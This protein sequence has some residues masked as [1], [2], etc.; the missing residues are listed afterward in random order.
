MEISK[1]IYRRNGKKVYIKQPEFEE[2]EFVA[3]L[4]SDED[5]MR[6]IGGVYD[7][8][9][10]KREIFYKN[11]VSPTDGKNFYCLVYENLEGRVVGEVSFH[12]YDS[13]TKC[14][15]FN[16]KINYK[17]RNK[18]YGEESLKLLL[19]YYFHD[20]GGKVV[21]DNIKTL[22]GIKLLKKVGFEILAKYKD[23]IRVRLSKEDYANT[24]LGINK[25][26][27]ILMYDGM[28][29]LDYSI[30]HDVLKIANDISKENIFEIKG[31]SFQNKIKTYSGFNI[32]T[33]KLVLNGDILIIP[34]GQN[35]DKELKDKE[36]IQFLNNNFKN[37]DFICSE[38]NGIKFL[39]LCDML[40]GIFIPKTENL[41]I[42]LKDIPER[43]IIDKGFIDNGKIMLS[44]NT[45]GEI[46]MVLRLIEKV[47]G[48]SLAKKVGNNIGFVYE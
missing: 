36:K 10:N 21:I 41:N 27:L 18:G 8:P 34:G 3:K 4:W 25:K 20:F 16:I 45:I 6:S 26:V 30:A 19:E 14:A 2:L 32:T 9:Q 1:M 33:E 39:E 15:R 38:G 35:F 5:T 47:A 37:C 42:D 23:E 44:S 28:N 31:I 48:K 24:T 43:R 13:I 22:E 11:M 46:Q 40:D 17:D 29:M 7:F 12:G